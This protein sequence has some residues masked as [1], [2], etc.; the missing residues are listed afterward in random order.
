MP[1]TPLHFGP[2]FLIK[3]IVRRHFSFLVFMLSQIIID[4]ETLWN[5]MRDEPRLHY[6]F[7]SFMGSLIPAMITI[8]LARPLFWVVKFFTGPPRYIGQEASSVNYPD[9]PVILISTLVGVW[10]HVFLDA[11]MH[12]DVTPFIPWSQINPFRPL[13]SVDALHLGCVLSGIL[14]GIIY[15]ALKWKNKSSKQAYVVDD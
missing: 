7:H 13:V 2:G 15:L 14:G 10:S 3:S 12:W 5:M 6:I 11:I 8:L 9:F 1:F 4:L